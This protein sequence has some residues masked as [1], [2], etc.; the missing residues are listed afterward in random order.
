MKHPAFWRALV[1]ALSILFAQQLML[2][3]AVEHAVELGHSQ[4]EPVEIPCHD[5]LALNHLPDA[6]SGNNAIPP[7]LDGAACQVAG[8][9]ALPVRGAACLAYS[10]RAPPVLPKSA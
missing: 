7:V 8:F 2:A 3:H 10:I 1:L 6:P 4:G 5:C 9:V